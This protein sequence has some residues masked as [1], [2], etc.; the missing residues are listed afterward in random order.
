MDGETQYYIYLYHPHLIPD[1]LEDRQSY[2]HFQNL[3]QYEW[4]GLICITPTLN[5][6]FAEHISKSGNTISTFRE[7]IDMSKI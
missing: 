7:K 2:F 6:W 3:D 1:L 5:S 4:R